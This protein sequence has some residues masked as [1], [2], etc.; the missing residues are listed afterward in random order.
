MPPSQ[1]EEVVVEESRNKLFLRTSFTGS[2]FINPQVVNDLRERTVIQISLVYTKYKSFEGFKQKQLNEKRV[3]ELSRLLPGILNQYHIHWELIEQTKGNSPEEGEKMFHGFIFTLLPETSIGDYRQEM[4]YMKQVLK[5]EKPSK[6][7]RTKVSSAPNYG[8]DGTGDFGQIP[9]YVGGREAFYGELSEKAK[10]PGYMA[11]KMKNKMVSVSLTIDANG[12]VIASNITHGEELPCAYSVK[13][14]VENLSGW[15]PG[16]KG[17]EPTESMLNVMVQFS[18]DGG[19]I[20][21]NFFYIKEGKR[22]PKDLWESEPEEYY[23][24]DS[25]VLAAMNRNKWTDIAVV[26]DVTGSMSPYLVQ[27]LIWLKQHYDEGNVL[28]CS[29]FNDGGKLN[30]IYKQI[31]STGGIHK[32]R[33]ETKFSGVV[34]TALQ[35]MFSGNGGGLIP[36]NDVEALINADYDCKECKQ[37][38]LIADNNAPPRDISIKNQITKPVKIILCNAEHYIQPDYLMLAKVTGGSLHTRTQDFN[39]LSKMKRD[40]K[41][42]YGLYTYTFTGTGFEIGL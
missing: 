13:N 39:Q 21:D 22:P 40:D 3:N 34:E 33:V 1:V 11:E 17:K 42:Q 29:F 19:S 31:G 38:V 37:L 5:G 32:V 23:L 10:C 7:P 8:Y 27:T 15:L 6:T 26:S 4:E 41:F 25:T 30:E 20:K 35:A 36:E 28:Y 16:F 24:E 2:E 12:E 9:H 18:P 14:A